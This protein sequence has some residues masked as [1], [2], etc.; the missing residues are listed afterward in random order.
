LSIKLPAIVKIK[1]AGNFPISEA[2][3][4]VIQ[5]TLLKPDSIFM[6]GDGMI[7][8]NLASKIPMKAFCSNKLSYSCILGYFFR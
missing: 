2:L 3:K 5:L 4:K 6:M 1:I 8:I 7:G